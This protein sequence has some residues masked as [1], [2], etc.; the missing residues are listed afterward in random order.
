MLTGRCKRASSGLLVVKISF[1]F[2]GIP[3]GQGKKEVPSGQGDMTIVLCPT[4]LPP[5]TPCKA[6]RDCFVGCSYSVGYSLLFIEEP[7]E[8]SFRKC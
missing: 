5:V 6:L 1:G 3:C 7:C 8:L 2:T 4:A